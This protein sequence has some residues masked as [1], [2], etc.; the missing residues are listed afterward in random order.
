MTGLSFTISGIPSCMTG[1]VSSYNPSSSDNSAVGL[2]SE[3]LDSEIGGDGKGSMPNQEPWLSSSEVCSLSKKPRTPASTMIVEEHVDPFLDI[4]I[5]GDDSEGDD[6]CV[7]LDSESVSLVLDPLRSDLLSC[8]L[9][10]PS[11]V[12]E[13][14]LA[15]TMFPSASLQSLFLVASIPRP[16]PPA[17]SSFSLWRAMCRSGIS[18]SH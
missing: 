4:T 2:C 18:V 13:G 3:K 16:S 14:L 6:D 17:S 11:C 9:L 15:F 8:L 7:W 10:V 1:H 5:G 12:Y